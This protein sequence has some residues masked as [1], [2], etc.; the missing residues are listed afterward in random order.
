MSTDGNPSPPSS[1]TRTGELLLLGLASGYDGDG[2][3]V[4]VD[5]SVEVEDGHHLLIGLWFGGERRVA[6][7][8][9]ELA[10]AQE[11]LRVLE[12]PAL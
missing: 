10:G 4:L 2:Q 11:R 3:H 1:P 7:L 6:L 12:L 8:P 5:L 9:E